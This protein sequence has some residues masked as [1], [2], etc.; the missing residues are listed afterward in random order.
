MKIQEMK[1][2]GQ[3]IIAIDIQID[4][5]NHIPEQKSFTERVS[6]LFE[7]ARSNQLPII[8]VTSSF[9]PDGTDWMMFAK[10]RGSSPCIRGTDG[11]RTPDFASAAAGEM[12]FT[13]NCFDAF[14]GTQLQE[15]LVDHEIQRIYICGLVTSIC[16]NITALSAMQRGFDTYVISD[17]VADDDP[18]VHD[19]TLKYYGTLYH[20]SRSEELFSQSDSLAQ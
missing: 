15:Y 4:F 17:C 19:K 9:E 20:T 18:E 1:Y 16:V 12:C 3:A 5:L 11:V 6:L 2:P 14:L 10:Q 8:H 13:K 7:Y